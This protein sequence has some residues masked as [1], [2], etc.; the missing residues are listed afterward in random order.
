MVHPGNSGGPLLNN[1][2]EVVG[3]ASRAKLRLGTGVGVNFFIPVGEGLSVLYIQTQNIPISIQANN[4]WEE[5]AA[6][7]KETSGSSLNLETSP[8]NLNENYVSDKNLA[9]YRYENRTYQGMSEINEEFHNGN[10]F[11]RGKTEIRVES[12]LINK[13]YTKNEV[14]KIIDLMN[15]MS[16]S[17]QYNSTNLNECQKGICSGTA[18]TYRTRKRNNTERELILG[19]DFEQEVIIGGQNSN[20]NSQVNSTQENYSLSQLI[21]SADAGSMDAQALLGMNY[22]AGTEIERDMYQAEKF[23]K[24]AAE[25]GHLDAQFNLGN[26]YLT[27]NG[28]PINNSEAAKWFRLAA[29]QGDLD[30]MNNLGTIYDKGIGVDEDN[31]EAVKWYRMAAEKGSIEGQINLGIRYSKGLGVPENFILSYMWFN[32]ASQAGSKI[33]YKH[34]DN[35]KKSM[36]PEQ[37]A[38][39]QKLTTEWMEFRN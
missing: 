7:R 36:T 16:N 24:M 22:E 4:R 18:S 25:Q 31:V 21:R 32:I 9:E 35:I 39:G 1:R 12:F 19:S 8:P 6:Y 20:K 37:I 11:S 27:G 30:S 28:V 15:D 23:Y 10:F 5:R 38:E 34:K 33:A 3:I 14:K 29:E 26:M 17:Q 2:M 13:G